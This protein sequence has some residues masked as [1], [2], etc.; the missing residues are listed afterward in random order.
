MKFK[1]WRDVPR[2]IRCNVDCLRTEWNKVSRW[3]NQ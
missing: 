3:G 2:V 1:R